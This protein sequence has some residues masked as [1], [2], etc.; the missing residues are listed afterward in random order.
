MRYSRPLLRKIDQLRSSSLCGD[1]SQALGSLVHS[2]GCGAGGTP[3]APDS[4]LSGLSPGMACT[5]GGTAVYPGGCGNGSGDQVFGVYGCEV[6][7]RPEASAC[8]DGT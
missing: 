4:C 5:T 1:G 6:G 7:D 8:R 2:V 3:E